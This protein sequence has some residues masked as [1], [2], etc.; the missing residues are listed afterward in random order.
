MRT[1]YDVVSIHSETWL[2]PGLLLR[3]IGL[4]IN[5]TKTAG[6][7]FLIEKTTTATRRHAVCSPKQ[8]SDTSSQINVGG[9]SRRKLVTKKYA[10]CWAGQS[11]LPTADN[12]TPAL[13][14]EAWKV[15]EATN[16]NHGGNLQYMIATSSYRVSRQSNRSPFINTQDVTNHYTEKKSLNPLAFSSFHAVV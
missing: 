6:M 2:T 13:R 1:G 5:N 7:M 16:D 12:F 3:S 4:V 14:G 10:K 8:T 11:S 9:L 15:C